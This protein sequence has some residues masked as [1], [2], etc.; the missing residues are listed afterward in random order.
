M[1]SFLHNQLDIS[2]VTITQEKEHLYSCYW[3]KNSDLKKLI[4]YLY[5]DANIFMI[6]KKEKCDLI[7]QECLYYETI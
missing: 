4:H 3:N 2:V 5:D 1:I 7:M 6:R